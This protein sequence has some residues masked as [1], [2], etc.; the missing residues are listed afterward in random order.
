MKLTAF[1]Q[2]QAVEQLVFQ[3]EAQDMETW[4]ELDHEIW[5]KA[6]ATQKGF[7]GKEIWIDPQIPGEITYVI[8]WDSLEDWKSI[9]PLW[10]EEIENKFTNALA[11]K[12]CTLKAE[13]HLQKQQ[14]RTHILDMQE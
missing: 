9:D 12:T 4:L 1:K 14:Y 11:P 7:A 6:L 8:Y 13:L 10:L 2:P 3:I 5:T